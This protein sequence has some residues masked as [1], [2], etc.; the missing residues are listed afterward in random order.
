M[1]HFFIFCFALSVSIC[2]WADDTIPALAVNDSLAVE[3]K[4]TEQPVRQP[5]IVEDMSQN[6]RFLGD[7]SV[8]R[9]LL[10]RE[11]GIVRQEVQIQGYRVQVFSS[12][13]QQ[14]AKT[15]AF[16]I[17]KLIDKSSLETET[18]V[19]YNPPFWKVR[20]GNFRTHEE[21]LLMK[22]EVVRLLPEL[23][24]D[25]YVVRDLITVLQ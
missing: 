16:R 6:V 18:Y 10:D 19:L 11:D 5:K 22:N 14:T 4:E 7:A 21:A 3:V 2:S 15:E 8:E 20:L 1:K 13:R 9:L 12:N 23:Q 17:Q 25:T 24:G